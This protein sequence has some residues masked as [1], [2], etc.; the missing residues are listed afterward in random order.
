N[1]QQIATFLSAHP[2]A[3]EEKI[4]IDWGV[5]TTHGRQQLPCREFDGFYYAKLKKL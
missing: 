3:I 2:D 1:E 4:N 5:E